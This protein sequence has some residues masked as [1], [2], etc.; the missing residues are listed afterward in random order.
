MP[1]V[2]A[3]AMH[4]SDLHHCVSLSL[5]RAM[6]AA[7]REDGNI[8]ASALLSLILHASVMR[9]FLL[10]S[11]LACCSFVGTAH[12]TS[13]MMLGEQG[14]AMLCYHKSADGRCMHY[15]PACQTSQ[16]KIVPAS[17]TTPP[18]PE[19]MQSVS[20]VRKK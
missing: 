16:T 20:E 1:N 7:R 8:R 12:A 3:Y 2:D 4:R 17:M 6:R 5:V 14:K 13:C 18:K 9:T 11:F 19:V 10:V 15:G